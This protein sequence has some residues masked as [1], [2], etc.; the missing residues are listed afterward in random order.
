MYLQGDWWAIDHERVKRCGNID[1]THSLFRDERSGIPS[2]SGSD[3][4]PPSDTSG[5]ALHIFCSVSQYYVAHFLN[6]SSNVLFHCVNYLWFVTEYSFLELG[7]QK[8]IRKGKTGNRGGHISLE[9]S[10]SWKKLWSIAVDS[11]SA[12]HVGPSFWK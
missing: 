3:H 1:R 9:I 6:L 12:C 11:L 5:C 8:V 10:R 7:A 2:Y 4:R